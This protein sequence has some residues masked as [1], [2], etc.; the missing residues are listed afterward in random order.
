MHLRWNLM[1]FRMSNICSHKL[2][3]QSQNRKLLRWMLVCEWTG[4]LPCGDRSVTLVEQQEIINPRSSRKLLAKFQHQVEDLDHVV[5]NAS[6][7]QSESQLYIVEDNEAVIKMIIKRRN[8]TMRHV[9]RTH[10]VVLDWL[11]DNTNL[12]PK[13]QIKHDDNK[14]QLADMLTKSSFA[15]DDWNQL[16]RL[17]NIINFSMFS[18]SYFLSKR[19][20]CSMPQGG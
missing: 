13:I 5:T 1:Y 4:S 8:P 6:S 19:E 3:V 12:V 9:S 17:W 15:C 10:R 11:F 18:C 16:L 14:N 2:E 20:Q 7:S